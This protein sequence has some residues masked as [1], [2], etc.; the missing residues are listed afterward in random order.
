MSNQIIQQ[1]NDTNEARNFM[2]I[3]PEWEVHSMCQ[4]HWSSDSA[5]LIVCFQRVQE[6]TIHQEPPAEDLKSWDI[7][8]MG[9]ISGS[10][11]P[12][13]DMPSE[14]Q[15]LHAAK[16]M[17]YIPHIYT[18]S[19]RRLVSYFL[20]IPQYDRLK[21]TQEEW[22]KYIQNVICMLILKERMEFNHNIAIAKVS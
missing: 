11:V 12:I 6:L 17:A 14:E 9:F 18:T 8:H 4:K 10:S 13:R 20:T 16:E 21:L 15:V 5:Y 1:F 19:I 3:N 7:D 22:L 2:E